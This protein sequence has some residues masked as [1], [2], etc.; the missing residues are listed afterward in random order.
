MIVYLH[1]PADLSLTIRDP[2]HSPPLKT[3]PHHVNQIVVDVQRYQI[4]LHCTRV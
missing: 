1:T 3:F 4:K 2:P